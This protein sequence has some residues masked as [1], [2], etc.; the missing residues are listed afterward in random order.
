METHSLPA[1]PSMTSARAFM[2]SL[3]NKSK[4]TFNKLSNLLSLR[5]LPHI[6][7]KAF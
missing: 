1:T 2:L 7:Y 5:K 3:S 6:L 4:K